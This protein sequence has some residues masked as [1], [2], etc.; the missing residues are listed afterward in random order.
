MKFSSIILLLFSI[1]FSVN[2]IAQDT[3]VKKD[4]KIILCKVQEI[5]SA[6]IVYLRPDYPKDRFFIIEISEVSKIVFA[7]GMEKLF[8]DSV[9]TPIKEIPYKKNA[10]KIHILAPIMGHLSFS[11]ERSFAPG[12]SLEFGAGYIYGFPS[13]GGAENGF[14]LKAGLKIMRKRKPLFDVLKYIH[15]LNGLYIKPELVFNTFSS[16]HR[17]NNDNKVKQIASFS[18]LLEFGRQIV[19]RDLLMMDYYFGFGYGYT[20]DGQI[21]FYYSHITSAA[22]S[23]PISITSGIRFGFLFK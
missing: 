13:N 23:F 11:Y 14:I 18:V 8:T 16:T 22:P 20:N 15:V 21:P 5:D 6:N 7:N 2:S 4:T 19:Y 1:L 17:G 12:R 9:I 3:I 10:V